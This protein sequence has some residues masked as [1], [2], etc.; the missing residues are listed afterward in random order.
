MQPMRRLAR[1][2]FNGLTALSLLVC[3]AAIGFWVRSY[4]AF[5]Q[6]YRV[7][8]DWSL[9]I[10]ISR[11]EFLLS[12]PTLAN[13]LGQWIW[14][15]D[16]PIDLVKEARMV[17]G[18]SHRPIAGFFF[19]SDAASQLNLMLLLPIPFIAA[20]FAILPFIVLITHIRRQRFQCGLCPKCGYDLRA[21]PDRCPECG[22]PTTAPTGAAEK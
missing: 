17:T 10:A 6:V 14:E 4:F 3:L 19:L 16:D 15:I 20:I 8:S 2:I 7:G 9:Q 12:T 18:P 22:L 11:G 1:Y 21:S 13:K 5:D